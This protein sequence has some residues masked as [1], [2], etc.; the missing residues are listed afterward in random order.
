MVLYCCVGLWG[1]YH[2]TNKD[3]LVKIII[4]AAFI[5]MLKPLAEWVWDKLEGPL[6]WILSFFL[7]GIVFGVVLAA[8]MIIGEFLCIFDSMYIF[9]YHPFKLGFCLGTGWSIIKSLFNW[10]K[11]R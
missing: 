8:I 1:S 10:I 7:L 5:G 11:T 2:A 9:G 3:M 4:L 6:S